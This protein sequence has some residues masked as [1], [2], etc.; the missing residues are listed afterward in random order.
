MGRKLEDCSQHG[1]PRSSMEPLSLGRG[2]LLG[3][4]GRSLLPANAFAFLLQEAVAKNKA[5]DSV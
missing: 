4:S 2:K 3:D 5:A 1:L